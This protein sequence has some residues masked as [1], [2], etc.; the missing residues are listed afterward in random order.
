MNSDQKVMNGQQQQP[1]QFGSTN[2]PN[3]RIVS[4]LVYTKTFS[5]F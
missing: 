4:I 3:L 5:I 1:T 2:E